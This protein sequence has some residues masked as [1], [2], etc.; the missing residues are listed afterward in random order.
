MNTP[1]AYYHQVRTAQFRRHAENARS[2]ESKKMY[3]RLA[4]R[5]AAM[6]EAALRNE[7]AVVAAA[8]RTNGDIGGAPGVGGSGEDAN[9]ETG[10]AGDDGGATRGGGGGG[11]GE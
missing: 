10:G 4:E 6:A 7:N 5:E 8:Q 1:A 11:G 2:P 3:L 9:P